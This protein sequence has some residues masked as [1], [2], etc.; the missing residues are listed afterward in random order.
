MASFTK[1]PIAEFNSKKYKT[2]RKLKYLKM[3]VV[4]DLESNTIN[5]EVKK[6]INKGSI[7]HTDGYKSYDKLSRIIEKYIKYNLQY[8]NSDKVLPW[9]HK[10]ITNSKNLLKAIHHCVNLEYL[11]NYLDEFCYKHNRRY[12]NN[13]VFDRALIAAV[14]YTLF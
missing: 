10:A 3:K 1:V 13:R 8:D 11:Q 9:V 7:V 12:F 5:S 2:P 6:A 14:S 4:D